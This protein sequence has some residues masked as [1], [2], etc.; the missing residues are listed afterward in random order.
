VAGLRALARLHA[1]AT[2]VWIA[3]TCGAG[4]GFVSRDLLHLGRL[5]TAGC[6]LAGTTLGAL[7]ARGALAPLRGGR[8]RPGNGPQ[9]GGAGSR[10]DSQL[11][12]CSLEW[13]ALL[14][15][16]A[17]AAGALLTFGPR[18]DGWSF[19]GFLAH[20]LACA[21]KGGC[22]DGQR[23]LARAY[24]ARDAALVRDNAPGLAYE[25]GERG[26]PVDWRSCRRP[27]CAS[28]RD[29]RA[30]DVHRSHAGRRATVFTRVL[31]DAG[32]TYLQYW[33]YYPDS[34]TTLA[35]SDRLWEAAWLVPRLQGV[36]RATPRY[37]G[38]HR[39]DW[40]GYV[41]RL[42]P[43]GSAWARASSH[44]GWQG[45]KESDCAG[46]WMAR[47]GWT[48]VSSGSHAGHIPMRT[49]VPRG[50]AEVNGERRLPGY[51]SL[52]RDRV[53]LLPGRG[54]RE[55]TTTGEGLRLIPLETHGR[56]GYRRHAGDV[57]PPWRKEVYREPT[58][59]KS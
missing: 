42:D 3:L 55:R 8:G 7:W 30:L 5:A 4:A 22:R 29:E 24:G 36:V 27:A 45:C 25:P 19:G 18:V 13:C 49:G 20:S 46:D 56:R 1:W 35:G 51:G 50:F 10:I 53:P 17:L 11:G 39:D 37:P 34:N 38:Y 2:A 59:E 31:R 58:S 48:R 28:A 15:I 41:V 40:E 32:R 44:G 12:Q 47:T 43:D 14:L 21:A 9:R 57:D 52:E 16:V 26:L 23:A 33:L 54:F 6:W